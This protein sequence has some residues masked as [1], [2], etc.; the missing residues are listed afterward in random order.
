MGG[1]QSRAEVSELFDQETDILDYKDMVGG[2]MEKLLEE[3]GQLPNTA[4]L[5]SLKHPVGRMTWDRWVDGLVAEVDKAEAAAAEER[6]EPQRRRA[7]GKRAPL[8][9]E[10]ADVLGKSEV[11][12]EGPLAKL[13]KVEERP[14]AKKVSQKPKKKPSLAP[15]AGT[16]QCV[17]RSPWPCIYNLQRPGAR[18][19]YDSS[20]DTRQRRQCLICDSARLAKACGNSKGRSHVLSSLKKFRAVYEEKPHIYNSALLR[21]PD[22]CREELHEKAAADARPRAAVRQE[23][24]AQP[25]AQRARTQSRRPPELPKPHGPRRWSHGSESGAR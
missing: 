17:G 4:V 20:G 22:A 3:E 8:P 13:E 11:R 21:L 25:K 9:H 16:H 15:G 24:R 19:R 5:D 6:A 14:P 12:V 10:T 23:R 7:R 1:S 18:G 2:W